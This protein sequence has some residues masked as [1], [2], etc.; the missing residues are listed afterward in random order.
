MPAVPAN[1]PVLADGA[2][3]QRDAADEEDHQEEQVGAD[4]AGELTGEGEPASGRLQC[5]FRLRADPEQDDRQQPQ[6][7]HPG[8]GLGH[9]SSRRRATR[10]DG[11]FTGS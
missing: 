5:P 1:Q 2:L 9:P 4:Q 10:R 6:R 3:E 8:P 11:W 7:S